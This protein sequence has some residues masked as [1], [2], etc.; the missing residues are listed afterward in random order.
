[1]SFAGLP[2]S[3]E[4][5]LDIL[6]RHHADQNGSFSQYQQAS[7]PTSPA[8]SP[9]DLGGYSSTANPAPAHQPKFG[10]ARQPSKDALKWTQG[11]HRTLPGY[12]GSRTFSSRSL[13]PATPADIRLARSA[14]I[15]HKPLQRSQ[16][17]LTYMSS[18]STFTEGTL[19]R[20][21][22]ELSLNEVDLTALSSSSDLAKQLATVRKGT[23]FKQI[24]IGSI[25]SAIENTSKGL[26]QLDAKAE[27]T[28]NKMKEHEQRIKDLVVELQEQFKLDPLFVD[29]NPGFERLI[30]ES[31][32]E[33]IRTCADHILQCMIQWYPTLAEVVPTDDTIKNAIATEY[34]RA[35]KNVDTKKVLAGILPPQINEAMQPKEEQEF[36][37]ILDELFASKPEMNHEVALNSLLNTNVDMYAQNMTADTAALELQKMHLHDEQLKLNDDL[38]KQ[39]HENLK[40]V[41]PPGIQKTSSTTKETDEMRGQNLTLRY[42]EFMF[43]DFNLKRDKK[44]AA[45]VQQGVNGDAGALTIEQ[46]FDWSKIKQLCENVPM[47]EKAVRQSQF[48]HFDLGEKTRP[49]VV[50]RTDYQRPCSPQFPFRRTVFVYGLAN[51]VTE[52]QVRKMISTFGRIRNV[53]LNSAPASV[54]RYIGLQLLQEKHRVHQIFTTESTHEPLEWRVSD[55]MQE[56]T[57]SYCKKMKKTSE[58]FYAQSKNSP[59]SNYVHLRVCPLC[60]AKQADK[61][62][63]SLMKLPE[64]RT[65]QQRELYLGVAWPGKANQSTIFDQKTALVVFESQRQ[66]SKCVFVRNRLGHSGMFCTHYHNFL[67]LKKDVAANFAPGS[68]LDLGPMG[69]ART[70]TA[71]MLFGTKKADGAGSPRD[72]R[73]LGMPMPKRSLT[74]QPR[75]GG[76]PGLTSDPFMPPKDWFKRS[77][78][79][80]STEHPTPTPNDLGMPHFGG[81]RSSFQAPDKSNVGQMETISEE[82]DAPPGV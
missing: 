71:P 11:S 20:G 50:R 2:Y 57:C 78:S 10:L 46:I 68:G 51:D 59:S 45:A 75:G 49:K 69:L 4:E 12:G 81:Q 66:A 44:L 56:Y 53:H 25:K 73:N 30:L 67:R 5:A 48:L 19:S 43:S 77:S 3:R 24:T 39:M 26:K 38:N 58:G 41:Y 65:K 6:R 54:D 60:A 28:K 37:R 63:E 22:S 27:E 29:A 13:R 80:P 8:L 32:G 7:P 16:S 61:Q 70:R 82:C 36:L 74:E 31:E 47:L 23:K 18:K 21:V 64:P 34:W 52:D 79:T 9:V 72:G 76:P 17:D 14:E 33:T 40:K 15:D 1:M 35:P 62:F 42:V 55:F